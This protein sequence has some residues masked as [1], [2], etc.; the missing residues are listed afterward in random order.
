MLLEVSIV[1]ILVGGSEGRRHSR[2]SLSN[3]NVLFIHARG[4]YMGVFS[5]ENSTPLSLTSSVS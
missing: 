1:V 4:D 5:C 2:F 3:R